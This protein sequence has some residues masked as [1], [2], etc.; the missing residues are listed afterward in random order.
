MNSLPEPAMQLIR[1]LDREERPQ[2]MG[3]PAD[4]GRGDPEERGE[5]AHREVGP[6]ED[7]HQEEPVRQWQAPR[8]PSTGTVSAPL[9]YYLHDSLPGCCAELLRVEA[10]RRRRA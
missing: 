9:P 8:A 4:G 10:R 7:G 3:H 6:V 2:A 1:R 5:L